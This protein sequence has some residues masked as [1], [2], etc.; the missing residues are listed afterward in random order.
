MQIA[1]LLMFSGA[2]EEAMNFYVSLFPDS[3]VLYVERYGPRESGREGTVK[4]AAFELMGTR[5]MCVDSADRHSFTFTPAISLVVECDTRRRIDL[6]FDRLSTGGEI[7]MP[8]ASYGFSTW[9]AWVQDK[10]GVSWQLN[11]P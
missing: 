10:Y 2:A 9:F 8:P 3:R 11:L 1:T 7:F 4:R 5:Y 6:V